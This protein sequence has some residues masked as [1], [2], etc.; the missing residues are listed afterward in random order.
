MPSTHWQEL[1]HDAATPKRCLPALCSGVLVGMLLIVIQLSLA[2]LIFSGPLAPFAPQA[3]G[4]PLFG[5]FVMCILVSI[6]SSVPTAICAPEDS[7]A[8]ILASVGAGIAAALAGASDPRAAYVTVGAAMALSSL[9]TGA[10]FL[11]LGRFRLGNLVRY[12]PYPVVGGFLAGVGWLLA[13][14]SIIIMTGITPNLTNLPIL[15]TGENW[16]C[17]SQAWPWPWAR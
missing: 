17:G 15:F 5:C 16:S 4:L 6:F 12:M 14:G 13:R 10:L 11:L 1:L 8:A 9:G 2:S 3:S 7:P